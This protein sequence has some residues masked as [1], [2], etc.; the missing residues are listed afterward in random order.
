[1]APALLEE[2]LAIFPPSKYGRQSKRAKTNGNVPPPAPP[3]PMRKITVA[4][5]QKNHGTR[6]TF[7]SFMF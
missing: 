2:S 3:T 4:P 6:R 1:M 7:Y 5:A